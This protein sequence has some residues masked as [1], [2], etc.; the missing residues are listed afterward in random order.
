MYDSWWCI[1]LFDLILFFQL[2]VFRCLC[3]TRIS[4]CSRIFNHWWAASACMPYWICLSISSLSSSLTGYH[5]LYF[6]L[7]PWI[8]LSHIQVLRPGSLV[9]WNLFLPHFPHL[10]TCKGPSVLSPY[11]FYFHSLPLNPLVSMLILGPCYLLPRF[12]QLPFSSFSCFQF[13]IHSSHSFFITIRL[14]AYINF[15]FFWKLKSK[16]NHLWPTVVKR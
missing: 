12:P 13:C 1:C 14:M 10:I 15:N 5:S 2:T 16:R 7:G 4:L 3:L 9:T 11:I 6:F 8:A